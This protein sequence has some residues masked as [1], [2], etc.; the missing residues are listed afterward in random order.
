MCAFLEMRPNEKARGSS[1]Q[2]CVNAPFVD[3]GAVP[4]ANAEPLA[5]LNSHFYTHISNRVPSTYTYNR[6]HFVASS[7]MLFSGNQ[8][9]VCYMLI[10]ADCTAHYVSEVNYQQNEGK[11]GP[12]S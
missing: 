7:K 2:S 11:M 8:A 12:Q 3:A 5:Q 4:T 1:V 9:T 6:K 10:T